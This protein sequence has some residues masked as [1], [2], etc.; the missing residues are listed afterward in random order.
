M[1]MNARLNESLNSVD[2]D[3]STKERV[4]GSVLV[5]PMDL[6][7]IHYPLPI[8]PLVTLERNRIGLNQT[9]WRFADS[10]RISNAHPPERL[11]F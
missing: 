1:R 4:L 8:H 11:K 9:H 10:S 6:V 2:L 5:R 3:K 7:I